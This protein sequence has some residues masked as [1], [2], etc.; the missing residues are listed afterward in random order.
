MQGNAL[1]PV[2]RTEPELVRGTGPDLRDKQQWRELVRESAD[3][4]NGGRGMLQ[5][6]DELALQLLTVARRE[7][8]AEVGKTV[9]PLAGFVQLHGAIF[10]G[11]VRQRVPRAH[12]RSG[13]EQPVQG[14]APSPAP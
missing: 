1:L 7:L 10:R 12:G 3:C 13:T 11:H 2:K 9:Q 6:K 14:G 4:L 8:V 5:R